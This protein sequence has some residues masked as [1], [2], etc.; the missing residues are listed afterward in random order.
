MH[1]LNILILLM[2]IFAGQ[3]THIATYFSHI[4]IYF[5]VH[6]AIY[7]YIPRPLIN[8]IGMQYVAMPWGVNDKICL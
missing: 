7:S 3:V 4:I 2:L 5:V 8:L 1:G 6:I